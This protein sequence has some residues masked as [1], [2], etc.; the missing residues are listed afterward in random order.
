MPTAAADSTRTA[1][2]GRTGR[3]R[4]AAAAL[5]GAALLA[6]ALTGVPAPAQAAEASGTAFVTGRYVALGD[7][8]AAG[9]GIPAL[10]AGMCLRSDHD[11]GTLVAGGLRSPA[12]TDVTCAGAKVAALTSAQTDGGAV[13]NGPQLAAVA[14]DATLVS[15]TVGGNDL[16]TS[17]L[18]FA[19]VV[20]ACSALAVTD[21]LGTPCQDAYGDTLTRRVDAAAPR[22]ADALRLIHLQAPRATVVVAGYPAVLPAEPS[23][24][25]GKLPVTG[26][27]LRYLRSVLDRLDTMVAQ[28]AGA[29]GAVYADTMAATTGHDT[30]SADPWIE[31]LLPASPALPLHPDATG[32]RAMA[33]AVLHA[34]GR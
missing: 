26:G 20:A 19:D 33:D 22:L 28:T 27:D 14:P 32:E 1:R 23:S 7:S 2:T 6:G 4:K 25:L 15:L 21:P 11:Y 31:G 29:G 5:V 30:C 24:C 3:R 10:T 9:A 34:L 18:G 13:V 17:D 8:Y 12:Y 16:G